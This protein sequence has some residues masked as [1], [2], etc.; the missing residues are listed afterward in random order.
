M[1]VRFA[2]RQIR[3][4]IAQEELDRLLTGRSLA[5]DVSMPRAHRFRASVSVTPLGDWQLDSDP[6]GLW[7]SVPRSEV[8]ELASSL[9][10]KEGLEHD[11]NL[12]AATKVTVA[13]EVDLRKDQQKAPMT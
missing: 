9:P 2:D 10:S 3:F 1:N 7:L 12:D 11:F 8:E 6:T 4:R 5:L 13:F